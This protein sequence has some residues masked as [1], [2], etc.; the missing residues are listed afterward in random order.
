MKAALINGTPFVV[1]ILVYSSFETPEVAKTGIVPLPKDTD[2][3][4]GGHA[5]VCVGFDD[6]KQQFIMRNSWGTAWGDHGHFY[7]PYSYL[8]S[9]TVTSDLWCLTKIH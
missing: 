4:L 6:N 5:V 3:L 7:L 1:G 9:S 8:S 2:Q